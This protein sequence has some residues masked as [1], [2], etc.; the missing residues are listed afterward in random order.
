MNPAV[1]VVVPEQA[2]LSFEITGTPEGNVIQQLSTCGSD[3][4]LDERVRQWHVRHGFDLAHIKDAEI[5]PPALKLKQRIVVAAGCW[6]SAGAPAITWLN[7]RQTAAPSTVP[8][9]TA[10]PTMRRVN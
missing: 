9:C 4:S 7:I 8:G 1:I 3:Q 5:G 6:G 10:K 2:Q